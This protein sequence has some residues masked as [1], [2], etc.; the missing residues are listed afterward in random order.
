MKV[1][2]HQDKF[3]TNRETGSLLLSGDPTSP[4]ASAD[5]PEA[6]HVSS[7]ELLRQEGGGEGEQRL[8]RLLSLQAADD[9]QRIFTIHVSHLKTA[10]RR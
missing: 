10:K 5:L 2:P 1:S 6:V 8:V 4:S 3:T 9:V 7:S